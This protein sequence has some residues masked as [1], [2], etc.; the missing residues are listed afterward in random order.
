M[1]HCLR[2]GSLGFMAVHKVWHNSNGPSV[3]RLYAFKYLNVF[4]PNESPE[5]QSYHI[6]PD[7]FRRMTKIF[8]LVSNALSMIRW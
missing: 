3:D 2:D 1:S 4:I 8:N 6:N 7:A 5:R